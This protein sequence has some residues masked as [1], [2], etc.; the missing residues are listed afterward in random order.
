MLQK[1][2]ELDECLKEALKLIED[3]SDYIQTVAPD[4][5]YWEEDLSVRVD[6]FEYKCRL[7]LEK[8]EL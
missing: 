2:E 7:M 4:G 6:D 1:F 8:G 5:S 3:L